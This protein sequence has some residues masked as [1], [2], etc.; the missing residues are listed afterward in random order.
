MERFTDESRDAASLSNVVCQCRPAEIEIA[1][2]SSEFII[3]LSEQ[4]DEYEVARV[5]RDGR[6]FAR[7]RGKRVRRGL[8]G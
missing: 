8:R 3:D 2:A 5:G 4:E 6:G 7:R 1:E